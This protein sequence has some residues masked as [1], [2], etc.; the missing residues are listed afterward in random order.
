MNRHDSFLKSFLKCSIECASRQKGMN[1]CKKENF[2]NL[3]IT[4]FW[5]KK[6]GQPLLKEECLKHLLI[7]Y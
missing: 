2:R 6:I 5:L 1:E 4:C 7:T 3:S